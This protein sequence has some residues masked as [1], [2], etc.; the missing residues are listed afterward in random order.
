MLGTTL[1][2][3]SQRLGSLVIVFFE[4]RMCGVDGVLNSNKLLVYT[5]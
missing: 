2:F 3:T 5:V 4:N 1:L